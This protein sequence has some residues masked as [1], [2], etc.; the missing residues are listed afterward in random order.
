MRPGSFR[1]VYY[2]KSGFEKTFD[3]VSVV[4]SL[5]GIINEVFT[6]MTIAGGVQG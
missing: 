1:G 5:I 6:T 4:L 3:K 2:F